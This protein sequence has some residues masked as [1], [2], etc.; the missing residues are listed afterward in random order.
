MIEA[1]TALEDA[2][3]AA[4]CSRLF[5]VVA[6]ATP[7]RRIFENFGY[8]IS[9]AGGE[10]TWLEK[11]PP[12]RARRRSDPAPHPV[13]REHGRASRGPSTIGVLRLVSLTLLYTG[14]FWRGSSP[15]PWS[16]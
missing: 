15:H 16:K 6:Q 2:A 5:V 1:L 14:Q 10:L 13:R 11:G 4:G 12:S 7:L 9:L 8:G 3:K